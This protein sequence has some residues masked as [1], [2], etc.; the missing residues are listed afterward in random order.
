MKIFKTEQEIASYLCDRKDR[1][2]PWAAVRMC[3]EVSEMHSQA[4]GIGYEELL[5]QKN[6][7]EDQKNQIEEQNRH[8]KSSINYALTIQKTILPEK[9]Q[10]DKYFDNFILYRP[11]DIVSGDFYWFTEVV[12]NNH[13]YQF[14]GDFDCTGHG[15]PGAF[16][17]LIG[18]R[19]LNEI[20][21]EKK[22]YSP[23]DI[24]D[25]LNLGV[26]KA[27][28]QEQSANNDGMD[29]CLCRVEKRPDDTYSVV[30]CG[31]KR[32]LYYLTSGDAEVQQLKGD[33]KSIGGVRSKRN[34]A[35]FTDQELIM[36]KGDLL[37]LTSDGI[38]DQNDSER[39]RFGSERFL[40]LLLS[41]R[42]VPMDSQAKLI[43]QSLDDYKKEEEQRDD[44][45]VIGI[46]FK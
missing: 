1:L 27:L 17:S 29:T 37:Y 30:F 8:I 42:N 16:M 40:E 34:T 7:L 25:N 26:I 20:V 14:I 38:I 32:P 19:L 33:R 5:Q 24:M 12:D 41:L 21:N 22:M 45:S 43:E 31:A 13:N 18:N 2:H 9:T 3:Q 11:K 10:I 6:T 44:I 15:V 4:T 39:R 35:E 28:K 23:R 36:K 46:K